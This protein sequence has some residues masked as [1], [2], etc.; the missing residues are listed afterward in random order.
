MKRLTG[1]IVLEATGKS[2]GCV[3][4]DEYCIRGASG[5][6]MFG[7]A[8]YADPIHVLRVVENTLVETEIAPPRQM[9]QRFRHPDGDEY[10][11]AQ[12]DAFHLTLVALS[13][14]NRFRE[15]VK[16][17]NHRNV[18]ADEWLKIAGDAEW[19]EIQRAKA[20]SPATAVMVEPTPDAVYSP[21]PDPAA[22][23]RAAILRTKIVHR[24]SHAGSSTDN[25]VADN[26]RLARAA[27]A[28]LQKGTK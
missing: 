3:S 10:L 16:V 1:R 23:L 9:G 28:Y 15:P 14:G 26:C 24:A 4:A 11:L 12:P 7:P 20:T 22:E 17:M 18:S 25:C 13:D 6:I 19:T 2:D 21:E 27:E 5:R 8:A